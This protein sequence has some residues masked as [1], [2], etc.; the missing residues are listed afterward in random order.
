MTHN[1]FVLGLDDPGYEELTDLPNAEQYVF[2]GLLSF[3]ELQNGTISLSDL[4][5]KAQHELDSFSDDIDAIVGY[6][7]FPVTVMVPILGARYGLSTKSLEAVVKCEHKYWSRLEQQKVIDEYPG[8]D[9]IDVHDSSA[10]L[11]SHMSYPAWLKP[12][13]SFSSEGAHRVENEAELQEALAEEREASERLGGAFDVVLEMLELPDELTAIQGGAY[14]VEEAATGTQHTVEGY[15]WKDHVEIIGLI[16]SFSY[17]NSSSFLKYQ[18][19]SMLPEEVQQHIYDV[20]RRVI[21]QVGLNDSTFNI[22]YFWDAAAQRLRLL[23]INSRHSQSHAQMFHLID[24]RPNHTIMLDIALGE[25]PYMPSRQGEYAVSAKWMLR[26]F[27]DG[28]VKNVPSQE[29]IRAIERQYEAVNIELAVET[30]T[31]LSDADTEDSYS[32]TLAEIFTAGET[33][34]QLNQIFDE[35]SAALAIEIDDIEEGA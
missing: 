28:V 23:E 8:F 2:H 22:E 4:L 31:R 33:E 25:E 11:P 14:M 7:D 19:P 10:V 26:H 35:C 9:I 5:Q 34:A 32:F 24:G 17:E 15:S 3:D 16:D 13:K 1:I 6:W 20:S 29:E 21:S 27:A 12:I 18:Y 30:G